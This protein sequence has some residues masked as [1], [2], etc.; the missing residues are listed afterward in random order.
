M[1][2]MEDEASFI[3]SLIRYS[4]GARTSSHIPY[5]PSIVDFALCTGHAL[6]SGQ[7]Y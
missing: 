5:P 3:L 4:S 2:H 6:S 7:Y 1:F